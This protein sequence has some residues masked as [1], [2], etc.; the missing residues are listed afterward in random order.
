MSETLDT[1][2]R[3]LRRQ[4]EVQGIHLLYGYP[5]PNT[6]IEGKDPDGWKS[7]YCHPK[8]LVR[9]LLK[10]GNSQAVY[11]Q[12]DYS[13]GKIVMTCEFETEP[14]LTG[15]GLV[16]LKLSE[17]RAT[18]LAGRENPVRKSTKL[19]SD[20]YEAGSQ[21]ITLTI[22]LTLDEFRYVK[23]KLTK[24]QVSFE[25]T[26]KIKW[27]DI[28]RAEDLKRLREKNGDVEPSSIPISGT[29][30]L[31][32]ISEED[33][34][35]FG[36]VRALLA[37]EMETIVGKDDDYVVWF[38]D[39]MEQN[40][41]YFLPQI[42]WIKAD[43]RNNKPLMT[44]V[45]SPGADPN[46]VSGH[47]I[48][49]DFSVG[50]YYHPRAERD[51][52]SV[53]ARRS[54]G[55]LQYCNIKIGGY[56]SARFEWDDEFRRGFCHDVGISPLYKGEVSTSPDT[57]FSISLECTKVG[58]SALKEKLFEGLRV[59]Y[60]VFPE[61]K[62]MKVEV[63][64]NIQRLAHLRLEVEE[65][66]STNKD[67]N[68]PYR[69]IIKN[70]GSVAL[71]IDDCEMS[72]FAREGGSLIDVRHH[73]SCGNTWPVLLDAQK[74]VYFQLAR[75][76]ILDL[77]EKTE[78]KFGLSNK[79]YWTH[80]ECA[81]HTIFVRTKDAEMC[82]AEYID[83]IHTDID[84]W[85]LNILVSLSPELWDGIAGIE[86]EVSAVGMQPEVVFLDA[87]HNDKYILMGESFK[88][89]LSGEKNR[90]YT[91]RMRLDGGSGYGPWTASK[92]VKGACTLLEFFDLDVEP[93]M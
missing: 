69:A 6:N 81:P 42:Y 20:K 63:K 5:D 56:E 75:R 47:R 39:T 85:T 59:G 93:L 92:V 66:A 11:F 41:Y 49:L 74:G 2:E 90:E 3:A 44:I 52:Y 19:S 40:T 28:S 87:E 36:R 70:Y 78:T 50:P 51:L 73:L 7:K 77:L 79:K 17:F 61:Q 31:S 10:E 46:D 76:D 24:G 68:F 12:K 16:P 91:Y 35:V 30:A 55:K 62:D 26:A 88:S 15:K 13:L 80:L 53:V 38:K 89:F 58:Y 71:E 22:P 29:I 27:H 34:T 33:P 48:L 43:P 72:C 4:Y 86:V 18:L 25:W 1:L 45:A 67:V 9:H 83:Q 60:V 21:K 8:L 32:T 14:S 84:L 65:V 23:E 37:W 57:S 82:L 64:L 54:S